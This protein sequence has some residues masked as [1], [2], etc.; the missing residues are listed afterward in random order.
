MA[1][2]FYDR[3]A[4]RCTRCERRKHVDKFRKWWSGRFVLRPYCLDCEPS[5]RMEESRSMNPTLG[6]QPPTTPHGKRKAWRAVVK[7]LS[8]AQAWCMQTAARSTP[9]W[10]EFLDA[11]SAA[12]VS[13]QDRAANMQRWGNAAP[14]VDHFFS[15]SMLRRLKDLY[16]AADPQQALPYGKPACISWFNWRGHD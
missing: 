7:A 3:V 9:A 4:P 6:P 5:E 15:P 10:C 1:V 14:A 8:D 11:Y 2:P 16:D 12:L 13:A